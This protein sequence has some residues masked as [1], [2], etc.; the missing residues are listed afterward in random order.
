MRSRQRGISIALV[1][2]VLAILLAG[3]GAAYV[4]S[5]L[6]TANT[7]RDDTMAR[8]QRAAEALDQFAAAQHRLPCP[9]DPTLNPETGLEALT[10]V[11]ANSCTAAAQE[12][13]LPWKTLGLRKED[14]YDA[15]N[16]KL[17]YR[18]YLG[19]KGPLVQPEGINM[20]ECDTDE[21]TTGNT[22]ANGKCVSSANPFNRSTSDV[23]FLAGKALPLTENGVA[24]AN[25]AYVVLSH[26]ATGFGGY[27]VVGTRRDM[28]TGDE[29]NN[30]R[31]DGPF[32]IR[33]FSDVETKA[34][35][36]THFDDLLVYRTLPDLVKKA[37]L[38]A[39]DW[40]DNVVG[41]SQF[42]SETVSTAT[43]NTGAIT[44]DLGT[45]SLNFGSLSMTT[46]TGGN[47]T[48]DTTTLTDGTTV[49]GLGVAGNDFFGSSGNQLSSLGNEYV[50]ATLQK[51]AAKLAVAL[52]S[53]G[54]YNFFGVTYT[55][56]V[57]F[58]FFDRNGS[59]VGSTIAAGC[60]AEGAA[61]T[62]FSIVAPATFRSVE[63]RPLY[64][65]P[66][67]GS[68]NGISFLLVSEF[69]ACTA[70]APSCTTTLGSPC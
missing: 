30:T 50:K 65:T 6:T 61:V 32:T 35:A 41:T 45:Q 17:S 70:T 37:G 24:R 57:E 3:F 60:R 22:D 20:T 67:S 9:A 51:D 23:K 38:A 44:G 42:T 31:S 21:P 1:V 49:Q 34:T 27:T 2:I 14:A 16:L 62:S 46:S 52:A 56:R 64:A 66:S 10:A 12:G 18:V 8:L 13:T 28:P 68:I 63:I 40:T 58:R 7:G 48:L 53:F 36:G 26:G 5:R 59:N 4:L 39:R 11:G 29:R 43:G 55:E 15:W 47:L 19:N 69:A 25:V 54:T 33:A